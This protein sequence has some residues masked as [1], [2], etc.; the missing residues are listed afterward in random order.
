[1]NT[2]GSDSH[3]PDEKSV[4]SFDLNGKRRLVHWT[5]RQYA[6]NASDRRWDRANPKPGRVTGA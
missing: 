4:I 3:A 6:G 1:M 2:A 5:Q